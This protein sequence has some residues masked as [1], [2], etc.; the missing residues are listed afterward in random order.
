ML[1]STVQHIWQQKQN[2]HSTSSRFKQQIQA[3]DS[4]NRFK[5]QRAKWR[6]RPRPRPRC[7]PTEDWLQERHDWPRRKQFT[8]TAN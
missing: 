3:T 6:A 1:S 8:Y 7:A 2:Q 4:S 5:H